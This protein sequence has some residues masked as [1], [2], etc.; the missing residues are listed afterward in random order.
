MKMKD[1]LCS[2]AL[3]SAICS[4]NLMRWLYCRTV[5]TDGNNRLSFVPN[6]EFWAFETDY[7]DQRVSLV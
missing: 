4:K 3:M 2:Q 5:F 7:T 1:F 6:R